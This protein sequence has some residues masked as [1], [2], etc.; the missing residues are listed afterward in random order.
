MDARPGSESD[1]GGDGTSIRDQ[2]TVDDVY[3]HATVYFVLGINYP[4]RVAG[5]VMKFVRGRVRITQFLAAIFVV[6]LSAPAFA[7][8]APTGDHYGG[9]ASVTGFT[10]K[11]N[12]AGGFSASVRSRQHAAAFRS[13][14][15]SDSAGTSCYE[16]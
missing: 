9:R 16:T 6:G 7:Q 3:A 1:C 2:N 14:C 10:G 5:G 11:V 15:R 8:L 12:A 4:A 13:Q